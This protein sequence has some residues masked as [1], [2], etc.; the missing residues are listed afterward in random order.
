MFKLISA[1]SFALTIALALAPDAR[2]K[3]VA[4][5]IEPSS[6]DLS[7]GQTTQF[8]AMFI[9]V[10]TSGP[11]G[12]VT[13]ASAARVFQATVGESS[14]AGSVHDAPVGVSLTWEVNGVA[15]GNSSVG[16]I[17]DSG[18]YTA[19]S[20][21]SAQVV[22]IKATG[23]QKSGIATVRIVI[24]GAP[25]LTGN[26][27]VAALG[28]TSPSDAMVS[29]RFGTDTSYSLGTWPEPTPAGGGHVSVLVA[30]MKAS[31]VY[32]MQLVAD[33][34]DGTEYIGQDQTIASGAVAPELVPQV[35]ISPGS[36]PTP[37]GRGVELLSLD[38]YVLGAGSTQAQAVV[39]DLQG[40]LIWYFD[41]HSD[42][43][44]QGQILDPAKLLTNGD[45]L[46]NF[47][48]GFS[49]GAASVLREIDLA[50]N[51]IWELTAG[52]MQAKLAAAGD[53]PGATVVGTHHDFVELPDGDII[54][55]VSLQQDFSNLV[56][57]SGMMTVTGDGLVELDHNHNPVWTWS[58]FD[59]LDVNRHPYMFPDWTHTNAIIYSPSDHNLIISSRHQN[60]IIKIDYNGGHGTGNI[61]WRLG[62]Q[63]D[64]AL[65]GGT[66]PV[67]WFYAQHGPWILSPSSTGVFTLGV[68]DNGNDRVVDSGG[69]LCGTLGQI[70]C[71]SRAVILQID[72]TKMTATLAWQD[73][74]L[75]ESIF[76]GDVRNLP[77]G[78]IEIS[79]CASLLS[80]NGY[81][82]EVTP[83]A[84]PQ[85]AQ[86]MTVLAQHTYRAER[87]S[88]LYPGVQW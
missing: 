44:L 60:W 31:T 32:H 50:G 14:R 77:N 25:A 19:P 86:K 57:I 37:Y 49:D 59:H 9:A 38:D 53:F 39:V 41:D 33:F 61:I 18:L 45:I 81:V 48:N 87:L 22:T 69:D 88:S 21:S 56:G 16:T 8:I 82:L 85:L 47:S 65:K 26:P 11:P 3:L 73:N 6:V 30:G 78:D 40:N 10:G 74:L 84:S 68:M 4:Y 17:T 67:D 43:E 58:A 23:A 1:V 51:T 28:L 36:G 70:S 63:G 35:S 71:T 83:D 62:Y 52:Q 79:Q 24:P 29:V 66:D 15:G 80:S 55:L 46:F 2:A 34:P 7:A 13:R 64:F 5:R 76:G 12:V 75:D 20:T 27:L 54:V 72:E 42:P